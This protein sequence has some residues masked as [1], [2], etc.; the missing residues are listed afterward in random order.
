MFVD[1]GKDG[2][3]EALAGTRITALQIYTR[4]LFKRYDISKNITEK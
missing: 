4:I 1:V 3:W 2:A